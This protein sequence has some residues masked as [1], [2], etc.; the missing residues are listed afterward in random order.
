VAIPD[1]TEAALRSGPV[2]SPPCCYDGT[3]PV[4]SEIFLYDLRTGRLAE[5]RQ[6]Q[7]A[8][9]PLVRWGPADAYLYLT[10]DLGRIEAVPLWSVT[11]QVRVISVTVPSRL[12]ARIYPTESFL[13]LP[14]AVSR[15]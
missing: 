3:R 10:L 13:P 15:G 14:V 6:L 11:A 1:A 8:S 2:T 12:D 5:V 4:P 9:D 7:A